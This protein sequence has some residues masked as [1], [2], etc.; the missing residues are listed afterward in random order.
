MDAEDNGAHNGEDAVD[1][2]DQPGAMRRFVSLLRVWHILDIPLAKEPVDDMELMM[3][4]HGMK[5]TIG[6]TGIDANV[7]RTQVLAA[8][9]SRRGTV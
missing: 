7:E 2:A 3:A 1:G 4:W 9:S 6:C 5:S 8:T